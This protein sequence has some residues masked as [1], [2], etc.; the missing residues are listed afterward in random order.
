MKPVFLL[1]LICLVA[2]LLGCDQYQSTDPNFTGTVKAS[3]RHSSPVFITEPKA[4]PQ[5]PNIVMI[6]ADDLGYSDISPYGSE[7]N[8]PNLQALADRGVRFSRFTATAMCSPT[9]AALLT[10]LNHHSAGVGWISEWDFGFPGYRGEMHDNVLTLPQILQQHGYATYAAG[11]WHLANGEHRSASGPFHAWPTQKGFDRYWGFLE[12]ETDQFQPAYIVNGNEF[13]PLPN[14]PNYYFPD[15]LTKRATQMLTDLRSV[16]PSKPFF[17]YYAPGAVHAP[18]QPRP[19]DRE[20]YQGHY[21]QGWDTI[22]KQRLSRQKSLGLLPDTTELSAHN[23]D[24]QA[25]DTLTPDQ[26][27]MYARFQEN[28]A[29]FVD[30]LDQQVGKLVEHLEAMG[31]LDNTIIIF[32]SDNGA[33]P[34]GDREGQANGLAYFHYHNTTTADNLAHFDDLGNANTHPHYP[35][36][37]AQ[38]SNTP[39]KHTKRTS[40]GGGIH[41]PLII[42]WPAGIKVQGE[43]RHQFHHV[44][45]IV[46]TL[47]D[48]TNIQAPDTFRGQAVKPIEG[49]SMDYAVRDAN[50]PTQKTAQYYEL[51]ANR[52]LI[53]W[54]WKIVSYRPLSATYDQTHWE[55]YN[56]ADDASETNNLAAVAPERVADMEKQWW[57]AAE[58]YDV[59]PLIDTGLIERA[60]YSKLIKQART[61]ELRYPAGAATVPHSLAPLLPGKSFRLSATITRDDIAQA[62]VIAA[63]GDQFSGYSIFI[64][65]NQL[66]YY[67]NTGGYQLHLTH[68][69]PLPLGEITVGV[70]FVKD[71]T[72]WTVAKSLL[73]EGLDFNRLK[74]LQG[75]LHLEVNGASI[76]S[77][78]LTQPMLATW[79]GFDVGRDTGSAVA[80]LYQAPFNFTG[81]LAEVIVHID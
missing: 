35:L 66:H 78:R 49:I 57:H 68:E 48:W 41:V 18:H 8:T 71:S 70:R 47:L 15:Q 39:F 58:K 25:W 80:P 42:S 67:V 13:E 22:R 36:G 2:S 27:K 16:N 60:L 77:S 10:G 31:E 14:D 76:A 54:P 75:E 19:E 21:Q 79:E 45:D 32:V 50:Q 53:E 59:L 9:R 46:P 4:K 17:L 61:G 37:W 43:I 26:Q 73:S 7:I 69:T 55:L 20:R 62:G 72:A 24:V 44:N 12:G 81:K 29:G 3:I 23:P 28:Y 65:N 6:V 40:H 5:A 38:A 30:N 63:Q 33:S 56:L 64:Q 34:E 1:S 51:E 52:A 11:K 74:V